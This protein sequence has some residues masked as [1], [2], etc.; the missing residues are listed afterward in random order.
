M[1][2]RKYLED[3]IEH[4]HK[5]LTTHPCGFIVHSTKGWL[6]ARAINPSCNLIGIA[7]FKKLMNYAH[8]RML[9]S[10]VSLLMADF[11]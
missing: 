2:C 8:I 4:G 10:V 6:G 11:T 1:A 3:M 9:N 7:E 5:G